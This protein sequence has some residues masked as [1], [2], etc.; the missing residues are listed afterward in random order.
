MAQ[1]FKVPSTSLP[2]GSALVFSRASP[3]AG[4]P[5][6]IGVWP[7]MRRAYFDGRTTRHSLSFEYQGLR[8]RR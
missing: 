3:A 5:I 7:V 6:L 1:L 2:V 4:P 8:Q